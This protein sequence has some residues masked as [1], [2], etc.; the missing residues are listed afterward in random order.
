MCHLETNFFAIASIEVSNMTGQKTYIES[1]L[2]TR[3]KLTT[4]K[5][6]KSEPV[7]RDSWLTQNILI[8]IEH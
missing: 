3:P 4:N 8:K 5:R 1:E 6:F 7:K 2:K